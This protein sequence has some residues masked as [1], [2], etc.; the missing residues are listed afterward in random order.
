[1]LIT[2]FDP[3]IGHSPGLGINVTRKCSDETLF[4]FIKNMKSIQKKG[5]EIIIRCGI[6]VYQF[7]YCDEGRA[8][9]AYKELIEI[10]GREIDRTGA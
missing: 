6:D 10:F 1:M 7:I 3:I 9:H 8:S 5:A 4:L 2:V